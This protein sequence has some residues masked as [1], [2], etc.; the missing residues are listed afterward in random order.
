MRRA[1]STCSFQ[2]VPT[3]NAQTASSELHGIK[4]IRKPQWSNVAAVLCYAGVYLSIQF[5]MRR[6]HLVYQRNSNSVHSG[7]YTAG[8]AL[9]FLLA[10]PF[11]E[12]T[13]QVLQSRTA[14]K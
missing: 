4:N 11:L 7:R 14:A 2:R 9:I 6:Q 8:K 10:A 5:R 13:K 1:Q 12:H 3:S